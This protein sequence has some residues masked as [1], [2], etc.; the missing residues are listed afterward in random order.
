VR[1]AL[2]V[3]ARQPAPGLVKTRLTP[4]LTRSKAAAFYTRMLDD[5]LELSATA[6][7]RLG[8]EARL[9]VHPGT[10]TRELAARAPAQFAVVAQRGRDLAARMRH[11][12]AE[13]AAGGFAPVLLRGSDSPTLDAELVAS[14]LEAVQRADVAISPDPDGGYNLIALR[15]PTPGLFSHRMGTMRVLDETV[16][17]ARRVGLRVDVL[18]ASFDIDCV[19]DLESLREARIS[20]DHRH[21][22]RTLAFADEWKLWDY[23]VAARPASSG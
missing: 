22:P 6:A 2:I 19:A 13:A 5:V 3:F 16:G 18:P 8:L 23:L 12:V 9:V 21:F 17:N 15:R 1:G 4:P 11:A 7:A 14:A 20:G 10:A